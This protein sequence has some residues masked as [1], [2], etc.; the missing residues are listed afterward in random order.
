M[1]TLNTTKGLFHYKPKVLYLGIKQIDKE[2]AF[3]NLKL[4][5]PVLEKKGI[6]VGPVYG[7]L[8]GI[9]RDNDFIEWDEDIDLYL[10]KE[11]EKKFQD[12]LWD[13]KDIGFELIRYERS[14]LYSVMR[15]GEYIDFYVFKPVNSQMRNNA[16]DYILEKYLKNVIAW[17]FKGINLQIPAEYEEYLEITYGNW[18]T[19]VKYADYEMSPMKK[20]IVKFTHIVKRQIPDFLYFPLIKFH[21]R[22]KCQIFVE[23]CRLKGIDIL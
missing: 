2:I 6:Q 15:N 5:M 12:V 14:G 9:I 8:L 19:P 16:G 20:A 21:H 7:T 11:D 22:K 1:A 13:L 10:L 18:K 23:K 4:L 17:N 3:E